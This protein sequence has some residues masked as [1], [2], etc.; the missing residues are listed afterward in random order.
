MGLFPNSRSV[1]AGRPK[2]K[3]TPYVGSVSDRFLFSPASL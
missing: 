3:Q 1:G 2:Q